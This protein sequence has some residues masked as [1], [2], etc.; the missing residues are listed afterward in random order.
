MVRS[1]TS[2]ESAADREGLWAGAVV[3][4]ARALFAPWLALRVVPGEKPDEDPWRLG[5]GI[6]LPAFRCK[7]QRT[8]GG[9]KLDDC[10]NL[11]GRAGQ[12]IGLTVFVP[13]QGDS[14]LEITLRIG[15]LTLRSSL[16]MIEQRD[17]PEASDNV[18]VLWR[19]RGA[20]ALHSDI[21]AEDGLVFAPHFDGNIEV[22]DARSGETLSRAS[23]GEARGEGRLAVLDVKAHGGLLYAATVSNGLVIFDVSEPSAP[24][25]IGQ[26]RRVLARGSAQNFTNIHN[27]FLSPDGK[28]VYAINQS[29][30][31]GDLRI[32]DV[33]DPTS[34]R[35]VGRFSIASDD[36]PTHDINVIER[37]GRLIA[38]L[39]YLGAGLWVLDVTEPASITVLSSIRWD[40]IFS[41][42]GWPFTVDGKLYYAHTSEGYDQSLTIVDVTDLTSPKVVS[43]FSTRP[44]ISIHNV[45]VVDGIGYI[46]YYIDGLR[47]V[48]LRDPTDP[49]EIAHYDTVRAEDESGI[50]QGAWGVRVI[51]GIVYIS[52][53]ETGTYAFEVD[54][55]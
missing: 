15:D 43:H 11:A 4:P 27:I 39:N 53:M 17:E 22:L 50:L 18:S 33:S 32:I 1:T 49:V 10:A 12:N 45:Q 24:K 28:L 20:R 41:H 2:T 46:S 13:A 25:L 48:D 8:E 29:F 54:L 34:P 9:W 35:E 16:T 44:G 40:G 55:E 38:F 52:D 42:S 23:I 30:A 26:Y 51:D 36:G 47:V 3:V 6:D 31:K 5:G 19:Q 14:G 37:D 7:S 21:W